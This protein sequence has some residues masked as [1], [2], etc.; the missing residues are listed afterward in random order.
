[1]CRWCSAKIVGANAVIQLK[2]YAPPVMSKRLI[3]GI[4][5]WM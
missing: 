1:M 5:V 3:N 2:A 4:V